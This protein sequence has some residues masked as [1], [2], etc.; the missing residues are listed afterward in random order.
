MVGWC[1]FFFFL[2]LSLSFSLFC[3]GKKTT[4]TPPIIIIHQPFV[5]TGGG[6]GVGLGR[7]GLP[8]RPG[9]LCVDGLFPV[10][11]AVRLR[12]GGDPRGV[13]DGRVHGPL[14][15]RVHVG[16]GGVE[17]AA[18]ALAA[19]RVAVVGARVLGVGVVVLRA[20]EGRVRGAVVREAEGA[21]G[22]LLRGGRGLL[23]LAVVARAQLLRLDVRAL[24]RAP[25]AA[26]RGQRVRRSCP[27]RGRGRAWPRAPPGGRWAAG[28]GRTR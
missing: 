8:S 10:L 24:R 5:S 28:T 6:G 3:G 14:R 17:A 12:D 13:G 1:F 18:G 2:F 15:R 27:C 25:L 21:V 9:E 4:I 11:G 22:D 23:L 16:E 26:Q 7:L 19:G 20:G